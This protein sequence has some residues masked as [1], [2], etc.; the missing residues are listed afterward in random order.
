M[1]GDIQFDEEREYQRPA[2]IEQK[3][4]F[5]RLVLATG[6]VSTDEAARYVLLG[7]TVVAIIASLFLFFSGG[8]TPQ[9]PTSASIQQMRQFMNTFPP[10][11]Y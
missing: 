8:H 10:R 2:Q 5:V 4:Y 9:K 1:V 6:I 7:V 3:P 11:G